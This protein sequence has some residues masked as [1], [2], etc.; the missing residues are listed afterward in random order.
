[1]ISEYTS[2][3]KGTSL[4]VAISYPDIVQIFAGTVL[5]QSGQ[6]VEVMMITM[7]LYL[8]FSL[9]ISLVMNWYNRHLTR[10]RSS[11]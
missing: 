1:M 6:A 10:T 2:L 3:V 8:S 5:N 7:A 9:L 4:A 11:R